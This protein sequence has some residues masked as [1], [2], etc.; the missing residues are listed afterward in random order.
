MAEHWWSR[1]WSWIG[2]ADR[3]SHAAHQD[4]E[5]VDDHVVLQTN[6]QSIE[7]LGSRTRGD[8]EDNV[9]QQTNEQQ[10]ENLGSQIQGDENA[11]A[12]DADHGSAAAA[13]AASDDWTE[14]LRGTTS[15]PASPETTQ[16]VPVAPQD[17]DV[18]PAPAPSPRPLD[19]SMGT[20]GS[21]AH[22]VGGD[23]TPN[24]VASASPD[25]APQ[26]LAPDEPIE[27]AG[28]WDPDPPIDGGWDSPTPGEEGDFA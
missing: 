23:A 20:P 8:A 3:E 16:A 5:D 11:L 1:L 18:P 7:D 15:L 24:P 21:H 19:S 12:I 14:A 17:A 6:E 25:P 13:A 10:I 28:H 27:V 9:V 22:P 2:S 4:T 26:A